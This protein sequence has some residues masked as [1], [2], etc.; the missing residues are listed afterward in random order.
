M[1]CKK[2]V[3]N[4]IIFDASPVGPDYL[5]AHA[6]ADTLSFEFGIHSKCIFFVCTKMLEIGASLFFQIYDAAHLIPF[7]HIPA[8]DPSEL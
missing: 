3:N 2:P 7:K 1:S 8:S 4:K 5:P 6:H